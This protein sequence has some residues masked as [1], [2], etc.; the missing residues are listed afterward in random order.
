ME[1][2]KYEDIEVMEDC[3]M[4]FWKLKGDMCWSRN[5]IKLKELIDNIRKD[6]K[7]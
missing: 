1:K 4:T 7:K 2:I 5:I 6:E 3:K